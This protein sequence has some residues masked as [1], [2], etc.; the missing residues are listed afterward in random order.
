MKDKKLLNIYMLIFSLVAL[1]TYILPFDK[2]QLLGG[3]G[4]TLKIIYYATSVILALSLLLIIILTL[5]NLFK[6]VYIN[7]KLVEALTLLAF[8]M[9][10]SNVLIYAGNI[11]YYL[12][13]GYILVAIEVIVLTMFSQFVRIINAIPEFK[14]NFITLFDFVTMGKLNKKQKNNTPQA[15]SDI[16]K[17]NDIN[18]ID[19]DKK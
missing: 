11:N 12:G 5:I 3:I 13:W 1:I 18:Q 7:L 9:V 16:L 10:I 19:N 14:T 8:L 4:L 2:L 6:D 15:G 17:D